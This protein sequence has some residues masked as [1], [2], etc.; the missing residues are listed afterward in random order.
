M[1]CTC[2]SFCNIVKLSVHILS[3]K[4]VGAQAFG[5]PRKRWKV[6]INVD[7]VR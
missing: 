4:L 3:N 5:R 6:N 7:F 2:S 1:D